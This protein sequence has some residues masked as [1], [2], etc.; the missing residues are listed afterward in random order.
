M[1]VNICLYDWGELEAMIENIQ[2]GW[3]MLSSK[4]TYSLPVL[5]KVFIDPV[6]QCMSAWHFIAL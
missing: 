6:V 2:L 4:K 5:F 3:I 1:L